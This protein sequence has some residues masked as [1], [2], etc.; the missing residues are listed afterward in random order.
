M[1]YET[2]IEISI[3]HIPQMW[4]LRIEFTA[5][6]G[7]VDVPPDGTKIRRHTGG[8]WQSRWFDGSGIWDFFP[9]QIVSKLDRE[10]LQAWNAEHGL[11]VERLAH[12]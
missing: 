10:M 6:N 2:T 11:T 5:A 8:L 9:S 12:A 3:D 7:C 1:R 4:D